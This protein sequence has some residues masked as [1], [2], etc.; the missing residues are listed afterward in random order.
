[1][2]RCA[3]SILQDYKNH[4][5][6]YIYAPYE[7]RMD[8]CV[9]ELMMD[10]KTAAKMIR[11]VDAARTNYQKKYCPE[12][13]SVFDHKDIMIDSSRFGIEGTAQILSQIVRD[14]FE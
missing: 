3:D 4:L 12:V 6:V 1:V 8:N 11:E 10:E 13:K 5:N 7:A 9:N 14:K 2:G